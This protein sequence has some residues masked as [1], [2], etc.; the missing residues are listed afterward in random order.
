MS[1]KSASPDEISAAVV[2]REAGYTALAISQRLGISVRTLQRHF[3]A[4]GTRKGVV[5][6]EA[7]QKAR[8]ELL[9][10]L[11]SDD[12]IQYEAAKLISDDLAHARHLREIMLA[13]SDEL[14]AGSL[15]EAA[16]VM[17]AA[18]AY[19]TALK[20]TSD[21][22]RHTLRFEGVI[23]QAQEPTTLIIQELTA[24]DIAAMRKKAA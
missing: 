7:V 24:G 8:E 17:R 19:S 3:A 2:L 4:H 16:L 21:M 5:K 6:A 11:A 14:K 1:R 10:R 15:K 22:L 13:A 18:A 20:N 9:A 12:V 23:E